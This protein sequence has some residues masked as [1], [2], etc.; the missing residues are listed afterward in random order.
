[1]LLPDGS[2]RSF[3]VALSGHQLA[4]QISSSLVK[5]AI[6]IKINGVLKDLSTLIDGD[7]RIEILTRDSKEALELIRHAAAHLLAEA[8]QN[9]FPGVGWTTPVAAEMVAADAGL[10][11]MVYNAS[12]FPRTD[13]VV[14]GIVATAFELVMRLPGPVS[15]SRKINSPDRQTRRPAREAPASRSPYA[16]AAHHSG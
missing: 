6:V 10:G 7:A 1:M 14:L 13:V 3:D 16:P 8:V 2:V 15:I 4:R 11:K 5:K 9:L 12:N